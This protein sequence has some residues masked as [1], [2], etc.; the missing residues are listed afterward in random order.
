LGELFLDADRDPPE[1][2]ARLFATI[3]G[4]PIGFQHRIFRVV[5]EMLG[6]VRELELRWPASGRAACAW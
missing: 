3:A 2:L 5:E 6:A 1:E 4:Q